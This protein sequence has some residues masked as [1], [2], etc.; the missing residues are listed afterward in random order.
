M[1]R[2]IDAVFSR[3]RA[4]LLALAILLTIGFV[5]YVSIP[6]ESSPEVPIPFAYV[7]TTLEGI[8]PQDSERL[9]VEPLETELAALTG[10][11]EMT[12]EAGE[13]FAS[14]TL[15]F[16]P[17]FDVNEALDRVREAVDR[18]RSELPDDATE[19]RVE[20]INTALFPV[21]IANLSGPVPERTL[22]RIAEDLKT[23][24]EALEGVLE[25]DIAGK[26]T[27][28]LEVLIDPTIFE[29]YELS[30]QEL[31]AQ[32]T[33]NNRLIAAG[34]I[35]TEAGRLVLKIPG[36]IESSDDIMEMP[37]KVRGDTVVTVAD[38]AV[39]RRTFEDRE[40][41]A[42]I[43][44]QPALVLEVKKRAGANIIDT[45]DRVR[46]AAAAASSEW[47]SSVKIAY[48]LDEGV[49]VKTILSELEANVIAAI[50]LV[51]IVIVLA[52]GI[53]SA[54][55][56]GLA[57]PGAFLTG[58]A[59]IWAM[60]Y[61]MNIIVLFSLILVI[62]MLVD[63]A[64]VVVEY[65]D[66]KLEEGLPAAKAFAA[67]SK[68]MAWPIIASTATTLSVF[69]PLLFWSGVTGEFMKYLPITVILTLA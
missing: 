62:G 56:V 59:A 39:L 11:K 58:V 21:L 29:T 28:V 30:F 61:T 6:K 55:L 26:R 33:R 4:V 32:I 27:E 41:F 40:G 67:A 12:S 25:V 22:N 24:F 69:V 43:N 37:L 49:G 60:G 10:L 48:T 42:R 53:R 23:R 64:I 52:L 68:R 16:E 54:L 20:E 35:E 14:V 2:L 50:V 18:A 45:V 65:A 46:A 63:G 66:R 13:G 47:P 15:E 9:L 3:S 36:L 38:V 51:M 19:P 57:I 8:S 1:N 44:G 34:S 7:V 31:M 5:A 17:S